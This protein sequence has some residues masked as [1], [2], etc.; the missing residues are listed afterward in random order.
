MMA[1][2]SFIPVCDFYHDRLKGMPVTAEF[3]KM[4]YYYRQPDS[5]AIYI[6]RKDGTKAMPGN[7][8]PYETNRLGDSD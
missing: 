2:C 3:M 1:D 6:V 7:L 8:M 4:E 5:C